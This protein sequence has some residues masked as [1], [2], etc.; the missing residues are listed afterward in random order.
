MPV[1][2]PST[3][4]DPRVRADRAVKAVCADEKARSEKTA[5]GEGEV[6]PG[7]EIEVG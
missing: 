5:G 2:V 3:G 1:V 4:G 7:R 6:R